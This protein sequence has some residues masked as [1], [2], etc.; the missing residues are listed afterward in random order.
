M[1]EP[2]YLPNALR[3]L[4][5]DFVDAE[6]VESWRAAAQGWFDDHGDRALETFSSLAARGATAGRT[7]SSD[8]DW[9]LYA[10]SRLSDAMLRGFQRDLPLHPGAGDFGYPAAPVDPAE[11]ARFFERF[12]M[13]VVDVD[14]FHPFRCEIVRVVDGPGPE[15]RWVDVRWPCLMLGD[16]LFARAGCTVTS[17]G[18]RLV[19]GV[20]D[21][22][23]MHWTHARRYRAVE[24]LSHGW[25][26]N[27]QWRTPFRRDLDL[28][29][30]YVY[31]VG[32][33][34]GSVDLNAPLIDPHDRMP[35][36]GHSERVDFLRHRSPVP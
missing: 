25:G 4:Y 36:L 3:W 23:R 1:A 28:G 18:G 32:E 17:G 24:D 8:L 7:L 5:T 2:V 13:T 15:P 6:A 12:G 33:H 35:G 29:D 26:S 16:M 20:A 9:S 34:G 27:S 30:R 31:N 22:A 10:L 11:Y 14:A 21:A 19:P